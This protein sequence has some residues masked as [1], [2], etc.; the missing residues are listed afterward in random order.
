MIFQKYFDGFL[1]HRK[2]IALKRNCTCPI[3]WPMF[4]SDKKN[5]ADTDKEDSPELS[6]EGRYQFLCTRE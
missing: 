3:P 5:I 2:I 6:L 4:K 1:A